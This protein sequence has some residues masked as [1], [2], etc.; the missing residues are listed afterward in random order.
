MRE[1]AVADE[2]E[3]D[4]CLPGPTREEIRLEEVLHALSDP[5]RLQVVRTLA[6]ENAERACGTFG[7]PISKSTATYH[8]KV[9][10]EAGVIVQRDVGTQRRN[11]LRV[12]DLEARFPGL[13]AVI[14]RAQKS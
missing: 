5:V 11:R 12:E 9:L 7:L 4:G 14:M 6:G 2:R 8:F 1:S 10:R 13:L 3:R